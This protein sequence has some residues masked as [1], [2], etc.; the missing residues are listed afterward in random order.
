MKIPE[1][2]RRSPRF[3]IRLA[4]HSGLDF[5]M[6]GHFTPLFDSIVYIMVP[7]WANLSS[8]NDLKKVKI[9]HAGQTIDLANLNVS[10]IDTSQLNFA[11]DD[12]KKSNNVTSDTNDKSNTSIGWFR[13]WFTR[14][15]SA[16]SV[17]LPNPVEAST[18]ATRKI[19]SIFIAVHCR[20]V[21]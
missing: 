12:V 1:Q 9:I 3:D 4:V 17:S 18:P 15:S 10:L 14:T 5:D 2:L 11:Q 6:N 21:I 13:R 20:L 7:Q 8:V 19:T 16:T